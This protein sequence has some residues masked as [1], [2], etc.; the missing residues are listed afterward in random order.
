MNSITIKATETTPGIICDFEHESI[1]IIGRS[2][3]ENANEF[4]TPVLDWLHEY[5]DSNK[6]NLKLTFFLDYI[7]SISY[8]MLF[9][10]LIIAENLN[11]NGKNV[12]V[13]WK[14][15]EDD[16]E[17]LDEGRHFDSKLDI[18]FTFEETPEE[19]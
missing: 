15:E 19:D 16:D 3:P 12:A 13:H 1:Q 5:K 18:D 10:I 8:K 6:S 17:I 11:K 2:I 7:N 14:Y 9:E 4:F